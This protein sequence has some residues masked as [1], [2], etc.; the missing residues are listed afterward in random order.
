M[1]LRIALLCLTVA[2]ACGLT[3]IGAGAASSSS[4][5]GGEYMGTGG[6]HHVKFALHTQTNT[7]GDFW[8]GGIHV[9]H[10]APL[11][12]RDDGVAHFYHHDAA[13]RVTGTWLSGTE[14]SGVVARTSDPRTAPRVHYTVTL[15]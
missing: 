10:S 13:F 1:R 7:V 15:R 3:A 9:F 14:V 12:H 8:L 6:H 5:Q 4:P 11:R 2:A